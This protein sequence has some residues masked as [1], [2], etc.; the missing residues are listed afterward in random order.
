MV[1]YNHFFSKPFYIIG[2][3][4]ILF[5]DVVKAFF[6]THKLFSKV[7][8]QSYFLGVRSLFSTILTA[9][10]IGM[11]FTLQIVTEFE[12]FGA[13]YLV[14]GIVGLAIWRELGPLI[15][16]VVA[17]GRIG[18]AISS[19]I[20][21]M[22][23]SEQIEAIES[24]SFDPI[25]I[26]IAPRV[27]ATT[28]MLPLL[29]CVADLVGFFSGLV[30]AKWIGNVSHFA[31]FNSAQLMLNSYDIIGGLIK[32][33]V[34]G[35]ILSLVSCYFG[36]TSNPGAK[37]VGYATTKA[38]VLSLILVFILNYFLTVVLF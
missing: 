4:V 26:L 35:F 8:D 13:N 25:H 30:I 12:K 34:F 2:S 33:F 27:L 7:M 36:Y 3:L 14:G 21:T 1:R 11:V 20:A 28:I 22:R 16:A 32:A 15:T 9:M 10:F 29:V 23:V 38:V 24:L 18:A 17:C 6:T 5:F 31:Y 37:G 19:E